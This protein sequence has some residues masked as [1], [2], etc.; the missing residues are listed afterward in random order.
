MFYNF[1]KIGDKEG[2]IRVDFQSNS[3]VVWI[4]ENGKCKD[5]VPSYGNGVAAQDRLAD[6][7]LK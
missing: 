7:M 1:V 4:R 3:Y 5:L 2:G 6:E